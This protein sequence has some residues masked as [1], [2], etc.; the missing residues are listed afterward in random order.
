M[1]R[2][3]QRRLDGPREMLRLIDPK[4]V[5]GKDANLVFL[6]AGSEKADLI[7]QKAMYYK[8]GY[9]VVHDDADGAYMAAPKEEYNAYE[10]YERDRANRMLEVKQGAGLTPNDVMKGEATPENQVMKMTAGQLLGME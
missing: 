5:P 3:E 8:I 9:D 2:H 7:N 1:S 6:Q 10:K 4:K